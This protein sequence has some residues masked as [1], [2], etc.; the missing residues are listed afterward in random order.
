MGLLNSLREE[1]IAVGLRLSNKEQVLK[2]IAKTAKQSPLLDN[3][4]EQEIIDGLKKREALGSTGFQHS[5]AIPHCR[6]ENAKDFVAGLIT[7]PEGVDFDS[8]DGN[9]VKVFAFVIAPDI[10]SKDHIRLL[11]QISRILSIPG[12]VDEMAA[13]PGNEGLKESFV[14]QAKDEIAPE[15]GEIFNIF[16]VFVQKEEYF[17]NILQVFGG[18]ETS[19]AIVLDAENTSAYLSKIPL[20]A[21]IWGDKPEMFCRLI[22]AYVNKDMTNETIRQIENITGPL[23]ECVRVLVVVQETFYSGGSL[24]A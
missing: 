10:K 21:G 14:R 1:C 3:V 24:E 5:I 8:L 9:K 2:Q 11:S 18:I 23:K 19:S 15:E 22:I 17:R 7:V 16:H 6:L 20:F 12:I 4:S 13:Q